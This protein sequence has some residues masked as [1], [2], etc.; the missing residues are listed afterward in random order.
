MDAIEKR[1]R[2][3]L[4]AEYAKGQFRAYAPE[5]RNG[6]TVAFDEEIRAIVAIIAALTPPE[7]EPLSESEKD[8][9]LAQA[10][11]LAEYVERQAK[12]AIVDAAKRFLSLPYAQELAKRLTPPE[13]YVLVPVEPTEE[14]LNSGLFGLEPMLHGSDVRAIYDD[15]LAARPEVK[16]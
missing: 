3:L 16:P 14:M 9:A 13:G 11:E 6:T 12:G 1:A 5:I 4:A 10:V 8:I 15:M 2:E 7:G